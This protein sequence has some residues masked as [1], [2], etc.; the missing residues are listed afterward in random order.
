MPI[1]RRLYAPSI[2]ETSQTNTPRVFKD[3]GSVEIKDAGI[4]AQ[5]MN[6]HN[7]HRGA[8]IVENPKATRYTPH[9]STATEFINTFGG[10][11]WGYKLQNSYHG[12]LGE[13]VINDEHSNQPGNIGFTQINDGKAPGDW[14]T[15]DRLKTPGHQIIGGHTFFMVATGADGKEMEHIEACQQ[16]HPGITS[17]NF[18]GD[19]D[20]DGDGK[21]EGFEDEVPGLK[22]LLAKAITGWQDYH[23]QGWRFHNQG[24]PAHC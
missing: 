8:K 12:N 9:A 1:S 23:L 11:D 19:G 16:C 18:T 24:Y 6:C 3:T 21:V 7:A 22:D 15:A 10:Y 13:G 2:I 4:S 14:D 5:Y 17:F 20:Y